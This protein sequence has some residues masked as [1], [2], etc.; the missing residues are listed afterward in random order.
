MSPVVPRDGTIEIDVMESDDLDSVIQLWRGTEGLTMRD[1]DS[2]HDL[3]RFLELNPG[4]SF[5][6]RVG[7]EIRGAVI[8]GHD[9]RRGYLH[10]LAVDPRERRRGIG[11]ALVD[12]CLA[13]LREAGIG[14]C[15]L[16]VLVD[17]AAATAFWK[18]NGWNERSDLRM[19][20]LIL[21]DSPDA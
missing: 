11:T 14:K 12:H 1:V 8:C 2:P 7:G 4:L 21:N 19:M 3:E 5:V 20:S 15:H 13:G 17:N 16:F 10:H 6:A 9:T 18:R